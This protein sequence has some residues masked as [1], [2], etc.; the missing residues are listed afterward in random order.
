MAFGKQSSDAARASDPNWKDAST[1]AL[2][3]HIL[4]RYHVRHREQLPELIRLA[5]KVERVHGAHPQ[6][7]LGL[8]VHLGAMLREL[9]EHM[10]KEERVLFP[11]LMRGQNSIAGGPIAV[12]ESEHVQHAEALETMLALAHRLQLPEEACKS[13]QALYHGLGEL[14]SDLTEHIRLENDI[15]FKPRAS[16]APNVCCGQCSGG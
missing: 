15:L 3:A 11:L 5:E 7:P 6:A 4:D 2:I 9:E 12:M 1:K 16:S 8:A 13:W 14:Y 10:Y